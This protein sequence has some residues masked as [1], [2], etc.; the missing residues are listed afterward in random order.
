MLCGTPIQCSI[1]HCPVLPCTW[2]RT[3]WLCTWARSC[4]G[5]LRRNTEPGYGHA[6]YRTVLYRAVYYTVPYCTVPYRAVYYNVPCCSV[7]DTVPY[8]TA[9]C[10]AVYCTGRWT[11]LHHTALHSTLYRA[12]SYIIP[13]CT[14]YCTI[15]RRYSI[16]VEWI[17]SSA[18]YSRR[19]QHCCVCS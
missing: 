4:A 11:A 19:Q 17:Y 3:A 2:Y 18:K 10:W 6:L 16:K 8:S 5:G 14:V 1:R 13:K 15:M 12:A 9:L 7:Y